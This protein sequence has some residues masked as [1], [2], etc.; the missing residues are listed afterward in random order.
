MEQMNSIH[1][2]R[3]EERWVICHTGVMRRLVID[4]GRKV[5]VAGLQGHSLAIL[6]TTFARYLPGTQD[7]RARPARTSCSLGFAIK[8]AAH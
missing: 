5:I 1:G 3:R 2:F 4:L 8:Y 7:E 6:M